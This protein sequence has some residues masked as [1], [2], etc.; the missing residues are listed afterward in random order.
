VQGARLPRAGAGSGAGALSLAAASGA[1]TTGA[2]VSVAAGA[3]G[4]V[5]WSQAQILEANKNPAASELV[6]MPKALASIARV[7]S[8]SPVKPFERLVGVVRQS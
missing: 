1:V 5:G 8:D 2:G 3:A 6:L 7:D 4:A